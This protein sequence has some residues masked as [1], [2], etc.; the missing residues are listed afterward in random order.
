MEWGEK[1]ASL[2]NS[3]G[4]RPD[5]CIP[6]AW[7]YLQPPGRHLHWV[8]A[9]GSGLPGAGRRGAAFCDSL[10]YSW[11]S[12]AQPKLYFLVPLSGLWRRNS[13]I[14]WLAFSQNRDPPISVY[15][16]VSEGGGPRM[17][18]LLG[19]F[20]FHR[21]GPRVSLGF[22]NWIDSP[23]SG[24]H[25]PTLAP[26]TPGENC[27]QGSSCRSS[28]RQRKPLTSQGPPVWDI[29]FNYSLKKKNPHRVQW[30]WVGMDSGS[31]W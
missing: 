10:P 29:F 13:W 14:I 4:G 9:R 20:L 19:L 11:P 3:R 17:G 25:L 30:T 31:W 18:R 1:R 16:P 15:F 5:D 21:N 27:F 7:V 24:R 8:G 22:A 23:T 26:S 6:W 2:P 28:H 12:F